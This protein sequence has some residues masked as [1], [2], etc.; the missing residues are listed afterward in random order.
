MFIAFATSVFAQTP[1]IEFIENKGQ[2]ANNIKYKAKIPAG[3]LY[4]EANQLTYQFYDEQDMARLHDMHHHMIKNSSPQDYVMNLHAFNIEFLNAEAPEFRTDNQSSDYLNY[5]LGKDTKTWA[6]NV[7]KYHSM[8]Y[9]NL[10][11][12]IDLKFYWKEG[13]LKYDFIVAPKTKSNLIQLK[14]NGVDSLYLDKG[15]LV[16]KTSVNEIIEQAPYAYQLKNGKQKEVKCKFKLDGD[17]ISFEFPRGYDETKEL[18][19]D[20]TLIFASYSGSTIDNWGYTSTFDNAGNLYGGGVSFGVGYP[21]TTGAYQVNFAGGN[22]NYLAGTDITISKFASDGSTLIYSTYLGGTENESPH[23]LIVNNNDELLVLGTT[24]SNDYPVT[25][26]AYDTSYGG[27]N[28]YNGAIPNYI[29][30]SDIIISKF[31]ASGTALLGS[32]YVGGSNNDGLNVSDTLKYNYADEFRGEIIVDNSNNIYVAST[33]LSNDFPVSA[34]AIQTSLSGGQDACVFKL[35]SNLTNMVWSTYLGGNDDDAAYSLQFDQSG[36]VIITGG[37]ES[38][39]FPI[40]NGAFNTNYQGNADGWI[41]KIDNNA[42]GILASTFVGTPDYDQSFFVQLDT[43]NNIYVVGQTE[44]AYNI[45][46]P[47]V[48]NNPNSGQ[49]LHKL[50]PNLSSTVFSTAFGT[51]S[52]EVDIALSAFLVN[53]CNH[54]LVSGWGGYLN[55][56]LGRATLSTTTGLPITMGA[57]Q[58]VTDGNDYYLILLAEDADT[59]LYS[60]FFGGASSADHVDGGTSRFDKKG[61]VYQAVC[62]A[63]G[64]LDDFPT[65]AGAWSTNKANGTNC[66]LGVFKIDL[67]S[68]EVDADLYTGPVHC[69]GDTAHFQNLSTGGVTYFWD[70]DDGYTSTEFEPK[71]LYTDTGTFNVM[72]VALDAVTCLHQDTDYVEV[73][74]KDA[75]VSIRPDTAVCLGEEVKLWSEGG[76]SHYWSPSTNVYDPSSDTTVIIINEPTLLTLQFEQHGC[77]FTKTVF[78]DT[79]N[80]PTLNME[81]TI[82]ADWGKEVILNPN[83]NGINYWWE[84]PEGLSCTDCSTP[85]V[86]SKES[87]TYY[88]TIQ[89]ANGCFI[90][91]T[92]TVYYDGSIYVPN[93]F[94]PLYPDGKND[95]F[96]AYGKDIVEFEMHV[97]DR[98]GELMFYTNDITVGWD[99]T[100]QGNLCK[101]EAYVWKI[102][103]RDIIGKEGELYG[104]VTL[105]R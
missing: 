39:D 2:W 38:N 52:G 86:T 102:R 96:Y 92:V 3:N 68:L 27:G 40:T 54:I 67:T 90:Y 26:T 41:T 4:L 14:Y 83:S 63:C 23:S 104:T 37:T 31:N 93:S 56:N 81:D 46:P 18:I 105:I 91:D 95:V 44:G 35:S 77:Q 85:T 78:I 32:T 8:A 103:F 28:L 45:T 74:V 59:L 24:S 42:S 69:L 11:E 65:T 89:G 34:S 82:T 76:T 94:T 36:N 97:F 9:Q 72:L 50:T 88:V 30:G 87:R 75:N 66:N 99:G 21:T 17:I 60:T 100:Y 19:I 6:T 12:G 71:H 51:G 22:G 57:I 49:F 61:I 1:K 55:N 79:L 73:I 15:K 58:P 43:A 5:Y 62:S 25:F 53:E 33:T 20:P 7:K 48:Y 98:W 13:Y 84:P 29:S 16:I 47:T 70:F 101:T 10:Y 64:G 80:Y